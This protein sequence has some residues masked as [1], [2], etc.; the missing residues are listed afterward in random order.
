MER[1]RCRCATR[2][3]D[4]R[5]LIMLKAEI[6]IRNENWGKVDEYK[7]DLDD[8]VQLIVDKYDGAI[9]MALLRRMIRNIGF[10]RVLRNLG[11][12]DKTTSDLAKKD[13]EDL[14]LLQPK[15]E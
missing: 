15:E 3:T 7:G 2:G 1:V 11:L 5:E 6:T 9:S 14:E 10:L 4:S 12:T 13:I 8:V